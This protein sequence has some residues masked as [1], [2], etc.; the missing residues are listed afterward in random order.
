MEVLSG[1]LSTVSVVGSRPLPS[2]EF[3]YD[4]SVAKNHNLVLHRSGIVVHN[5]PDRFY[6]F[7]PPTSAGTVNQFNR[8]FGYV[9]EDEELA[10]YLEQAV[11]TVNMYPPNTEGLYRDLDNML[12]RRPSWRSLIVC[13]TMVDA[14]RALQAN[15]VVDAFSYSIGGISLDLNEKVSAYQSLADSMKQQFDTQ[16]V[17][18]KKVEKYTKGLRQSKFN[19]G[20]RS[21]RVGPYS[22]SGVMSPRNWIMWG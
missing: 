21:G 5:C 15:W 4:L 20:F 2:R 6:H 11:D 12:V 18:A 10:E 1:D 8:V 13:A 14:F 3:V 7:R 17:E 19:P 16:I 9:W 22:G